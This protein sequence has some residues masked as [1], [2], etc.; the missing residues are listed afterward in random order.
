MSHEL[1]T[2]LQAI[3]G[4]TDLVIEEL[5]AAGNYSYSDQLMRVTSNSERL[6]TLINNTLDLA[7]IEGG[8]MEVQ[9]TRTNLSAL[10]DEAASNINPLLKKNENQLFINIDDNTHTPSID[11]EKS[12]QILVNLLSNATKFTKNG[13]ITVSL[14]N[15]PEH[16]KLTVHDTGVGL[17]KDQLDTIFYQFHQVDHKGAIKTKGTGLGLSI[18]K[19]FCELMG[20]SIIVKSEAGIGTSFIVDIPLPVIINSNKSLDL[21]AD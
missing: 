20:G 2:P 5:E 7:K 14:I 18:T 17:T 4:Y 15:S 21:H 13:T 8:K 9:L 16:L 10:I 19:H 11:Y 3:M 12:L 6:L 1:R